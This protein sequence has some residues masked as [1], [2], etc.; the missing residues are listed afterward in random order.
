MRIFCEG[1]PPFGEPC[2]AVVDFLPTADKGND[3]SPL[4]MPIH[5]AKDHFGF[6]DVPNWWPFLVFLGV[7]FSVPRALSFIKHNCIFVG[8]LIDRSVKIVFYEMMYILHERLN[9]FP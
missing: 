1:P 8:S 9:V 3:R 4:L 2:F 5:N 7:L 6:G